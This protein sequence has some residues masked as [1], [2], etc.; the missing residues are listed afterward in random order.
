MYYVRDIEIYSSSF[1]AIEGSVFIQEIFI[2]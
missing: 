2:L 1:E